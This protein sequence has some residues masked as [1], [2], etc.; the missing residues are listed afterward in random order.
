[1]LG[2]SDSRV[3]RPHGVF[4]DGKTAQA[5]PVSINVLSNGLQIYGERAQSH[6]AWSFEGLRAQ[7]GLRSAEAQF[8]HEDH[9]DARLVITD[10]AVLA[11]IGTVAPGALAGRGPRGGALRL[12]GMGVLIAALLAGIVF[13][14][15]PRSAGVV[16]DAIPRKWENEWGKGI[17]QK[18]AGKNKVCAGK[19]G[20]AAFDALTARLLGT[21]A[22]RNSGYKLTFTVI[23][24][25]TQNAFATMGGQIV[26]F[27]KLIEEMKGPDELAG[28]LAHEIGHVTARHPLIGT[29]EA[30]FTM[31]FAS[32]FGGGS[33]DMGGGMASLGGV[34]AVTSYSRAK[35]TDADET[36]AR[37]L[38]EAGITLDGLADFFARLQRAHKGTNSK[39]LAVFSTH[40]AL[41]ERAAQLRKLGRAAGPTAPALTPAQ[42]QALKGICG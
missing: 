27:S 13:V 32:L 7:P 4:F 22:V 19:S 30:T 37:I 3:R 38:N 11:R 23:E 15:L 24:T 25:K 42:W 1:M 33:S 16:A 41:G 17:A 35:E 2:P 5:R 18:F 34:L 40:P 39:A 36:A 31:M 26:V 6:G 29:I 8:M 10:S 21:E 9:P 20:R 12:V 28:V 14:I